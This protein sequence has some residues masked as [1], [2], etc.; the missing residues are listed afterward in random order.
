M[1]SR[2][3]SFKDQLWY[4]WSVKAIA[5]QVGAKPFFLNPEE[6]TIDCSKISSL[7]DIDVT[8]GGQKFT[9]TGKDYVINAGPLCLFGMTGIDV[10]APMGPLWIMGD[11]FMR[12]F[13]VVFDAGKERLGIAPAK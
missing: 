12:K 1:C 9:L 6:Y 3:L 7:P 8:M 2:H 4:W 5:K 11:V 10:P 13:Y